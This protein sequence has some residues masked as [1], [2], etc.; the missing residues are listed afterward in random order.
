MPYIP[1][2]PVESS[3]IAE[4]GYDRKRRTL[5]VIF[6][7]DR[8]Y[9]Y[10]DVMERAYK[11]LMA[12]DSKGKHFNRRIKPVYTYRNVTRPQELKAP[13]CDHPERDTCDETC[14]PCDEWCCPG[15][16]TE[17][18][19]IPFCPDCKTQCEA[20][21][22]ALACPHGKDDQ[23]CD[24]TCACHCHEP[25]DQ[26]PVRKAGEDLADLPA[27]AEAAL[28]S[29][30]AMDGMSMLELVGTAEIRVSQALQ[31][32]PLPALVA[33]RDKLAELRVLCEEFGR[34]LC[35]DCGDTPGAIDGPPTTHVP[36]P[37]LTTAA[38]VAA[39]MPPPPD[40]PC[41]GDDAGCVD[42]SPSPEEDPET[43]EDDG[44]ET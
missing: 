41:A 34:A 23:D 24:E 11:E 8:V 15:P 1:T 2:E 28:A 30:A 27:E 40:A 14:W 4:I 25:A 18:E 37:P 39:E 12:A 7:N 42:Q 16:P 26:E 6:H 43:E 38:E 17:G 13:C 10:P 20:C 31:E 29:A 21:I 36:D 32:H 35:G 9:D 3:N 33:I 5:R 44:N 22:A 19:V